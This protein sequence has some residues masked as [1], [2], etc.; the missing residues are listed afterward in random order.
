M[1]LKIGVLVA[2]GKGYPAL[3]AEIYDLFY[4]WKYF[5]NLDQNNYKQKPPKNGYKEHVKL[6]A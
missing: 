5:V 6:G 2:G 1:L 3:L 4:N